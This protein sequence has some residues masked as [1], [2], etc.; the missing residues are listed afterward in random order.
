MVMKIGTFFTAIVVLV[1]GIPVEASAANIWDGTYTG[2]GIS[3][4]DQITLSGSTLSGTT[5]LGCTTCVAPILPL[6]G[7]VSRVLNGFANLS[8]NPAG[9]LLLPPGIVVGI[10]SGAPAT[11]ATFQIDWLKGGPDGVD[12]GPTVQYQSIINGAVTITTAG[13]KISATFTP[14]FDL[15]LL[16]AAQLGGFDFFDWTQTVTYSPLPSPF[17]AHS[18]PYLPLVAPYADPP[19][20]GGYQY[21]WDDPNVGPDY[22]YPYYDNPVSAFGS[23]PGSELATQETGNGAT[24]FAPQR[25]NTL[26]FSDN[27]ADPCLTGGNGA[28]CGGLTVPAG[29]KSENDFTTDLVGVT[30]LGQII[31]LFQFTWSDNF[32]GT[33]GGVARTKNDLPVDPGSGTGGVTL[34]SESYLLGSPVPEPSTWALLLVGFAGLGLAGLRA[35]SQGAASLRLKRPRLGGCSSAV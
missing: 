15:T 13:T 27:P 1:V 20:G 25:A 10:S 29:E 6:T 34:L 31:D 23:L 28:G 32:N 35:S 19:P 5:N 22:A 30:D 4:D 17:F 16:E 14:N 21:E 8:L 7:T 3:E 33:S 12:I 11:T 9:G 18:N 2:S 26:N 24:P